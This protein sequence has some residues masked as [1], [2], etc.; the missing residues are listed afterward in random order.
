MVTE[1]RHARLAEGRPP[2]LDQ[3]EQVLVRE[4]VDEPRVSQVVRAEQ[5]EP[6]APRAVAV[7]GVAGGAVGQVEALPAGGG[8]G[9]R[10]GQEEHRQDAPDQ[11]EQGG[12]EHHDHPL[13]LHGRRGYHAGRHALEVV[14]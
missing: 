8:L 13:R 9:D 1:G 2:V 6:R 12:T 10:M 3:R 11:H 4:R 14:R 7:R 5:E